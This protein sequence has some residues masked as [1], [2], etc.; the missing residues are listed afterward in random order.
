MKYETSAGGVIFYFTNKK[1]PQLILLQDK[2]G[3]WTFP[4]GLVKRGEDKQKTAEREIYEEVGI[5]SLRLLTKLSPIEY[6]Y[7]WDGQ[8]V[9]KK[10][11]Y[12]LFLYEGH[13]KIKPQTEEG[14]LDVKW[15]SIDEAKKLVGYKKTNQKILQAAIKKAQKIFRD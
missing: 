1:N 15:F 12:F 14:I 9:K 2:N 5:K 7:R 13:D 8:L 4:K 3:V 10:V 11:Y 6:F